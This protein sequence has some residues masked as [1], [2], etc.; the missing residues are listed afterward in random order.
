MTSDR[1]D[2]GGKDGE[3]V[4][5]QNQGVNPEPSERTIRERAERALTWFL[6]IALVVSLGG[7]VYVAIEPPETTDPYT[8]FYL[9]GPTGN[10]SG[11]PTALEPGETGP[12]V[13]GISN[14]EHE[15][16]NYRAVVVWNSSQTQERQVTVAD[17][18]TREFWMNVTAPESTGKYKV[19]VLLYNSSQSVD[20]PYQSLRLWVRVGNGSDTIN[21]SSNATQAHTISSQ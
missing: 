9:L 2:A 10:A 14:H 21:S 19:Q 15:R 1:D 5:D 17:D 11:Y 16:T 13:V 7:V 3:Q 12:L 8:E 6:A 18:E 4:G 20:D